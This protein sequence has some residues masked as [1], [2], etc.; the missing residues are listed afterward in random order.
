[1]LNEIRIQRQLK[2][3]G[4]VIKLIKIYESDNYLNLLME[5]QEGGCLGDILEKQIKISEQN[6]R[7]IIA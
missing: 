1:M 2:L 5:Y 7:L 6:A 3:C 4:N